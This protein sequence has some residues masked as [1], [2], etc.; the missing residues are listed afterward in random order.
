MIGQ[1][2]FVLGNS[3]IHHVTVCHLIS[4]SKKGGPPLLTK[5]GG[6]LPNFGS[7]L[8]P[9]P[10]NFK[11]LDEHDGGPCFSKDIFN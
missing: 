11:K 9:F 10:I 4:L 8:P 2:C 7:F 6:R 1:Y 5:D 3:R